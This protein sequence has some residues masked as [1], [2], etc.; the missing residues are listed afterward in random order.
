MKATDPTL[1]PYA[2]PGTAGPSR[3]FSVW[4]F[5][6]IGLLLAHVVGMLSVVTIFNRNKPP[7]VENYYQKAV[8][9]DADRGIAPGGK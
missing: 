6:V 5:I 8:N 1:V 4:P 2:G 3:R 9:W 7:V